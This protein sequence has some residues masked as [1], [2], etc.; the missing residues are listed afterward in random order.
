MPSLPLF[1]SFLSFSLLILSVIDS[2][3][4]LTYLKLNFFST[5]INDLEYRITRKGKGPYRKSES[6]KK[7][8]LTVHMSEDGQIV[9][10]TLF[11]RC[12]NFSNTPKYDWN[13][14][15]HVFLVIWET[16]SEICHI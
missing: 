15:L 16:H 6:A 10:E 4:D 1:N 5:K 14:I 2:F 13:T 11:K 7:V 9:Q 12:G 3:A 8:N